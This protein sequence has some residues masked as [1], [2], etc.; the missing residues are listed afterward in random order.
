MSEETLVKDL[1][2]R[3]N[4]FEPGDLVC[5]M[6]I[7][8]FVDSFK[9]D[10]P[11]NRKDVVLDLSALFHCYI[12][13]GENEELN[14][15]LEE[16]KSQL[17][18]ILSQESPI[19]PQ[20]S[21]VLIED[22]EVL[23][24]FIQESHDHLDTIED[25]ILT[26]EN[27]SDSDLIDDIFRS[28]HTIKG[29]S[30]FIG[31]NNIQSLSH[32]LESLLDR[33][34]INELKINSDLISILLDGTDILANMIHF[35]EKESESK[36]NG[37]QS[38]TITEPTIDY[39]P[40][41]EKIR[42][43]DILSLSEK[44][45]TEILA[46]PEISKLSD[47]KSSENNSL[48]SDDLITEEMIRKFIEESLDLLD[49]AE[50]SVLELE[51]SS[52][53][54]E[55]IDNAFRNL[56]TIKGNSGFFGFEVIEDS[57][58]EA[59]TLLDQI[60]KGINK[61]D[62][63]NI[64][65]ILQKL[66]N[67]RN[68]MNQLLIPVKK[69]ETAG[70]PY[71][72]LGEVLVDMGV[73]R[74][75]IEHAV[76]IQSKKIGEILVDEGAVSSSTLNKALQ[77]QNKAMSNAPAISIKRKDIRIDMEKLDKL[78]DMV[79][80]LIT[81]EAMVVD[82]EDL[83]GLEMRD[84]NKSALYLSKIT[85]EIQSITMSMRMIPL[86]GLFKKMKRLV[87]DL[88]KKMDKPVQFFISGA[89]TEMDRNVTEEIA[90]PLVHIIRNSIDHGLENREER[91]KAGKNPVG[92]VKLNAR[93][94]GNEIWITVSDDGAGLNSQKILKSAISKGLVKGDPDLMEPKDVWKLIFEP[95]FS[96]ADQISEISGR[97][98]GMD[99]VRRNI[100]KLRGGIDIN[101]RDG[102]GTDIILRI[103]LT[104]A[105]IDAI[106]FKVSHLIMA[107]QS[108]DVIE[109]LKPK[110]ELFTETRKGHQVI[111][112]RSEIIPIIDMRSF[113]NLENEII[114]VNERVLIVIHA[115]G[116]KA[117]LFVDGIVGSKQMV[118][119]ALPEIL[120]ETRAVSGCSLMG[121]G[122]VCMVLDA[123]ALIK[124]T[125]EG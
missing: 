122:D 42:N 20:I 34:R 43:I 24:S 30:S 2:D 113:Y 103:P 36:G 107:L 118:V 99:V 3:I 121:N 88:S 74:A 76:D 101:S 23:S 123:A 9:N 15:K 10:F 81:A 14:R 108:S 115:A 13:E 72:P 65:V 16:L 87:R 93:Y 92:V 39:A 96:T 28:M 79:G 6:E 62:Q 68:M 70:N 125:F 116:K 52:N 120:E 100:E 78:F 86:E 80:E 59:E 49:S 32:S 117:A 71:K 111:S 102:E 4:L 67:I 38:Y 89:D 48:N 73:S 83:K 7:K 61:A 40:L 51:D 57:S 77:T 19:S 75:D 124:E 47:L 27:G 110:A 90:D 31:L 84:F 41:I 56:H 33:L 63:R 11:E 1:L 12:L 44:E 119:K 91:R 58:M 22:H 97:G 8:E 112:L 21:F 17:L 82:S 53:I 109:F 55:S 95:G 60:R 18:E 66:D 50:H 104:L 114:N 54:G 29:V 64:S 5:T 94:E 105:I 46:E 69:G 45:E 35:I 106:S 26:L 85:R 37:K 98:V 25:R